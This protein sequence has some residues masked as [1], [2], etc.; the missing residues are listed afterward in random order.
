MYRKQFRKR[1]FYSFGISIVGLFIC[2]F[3]VDKIFNGFIYGLLYSFS[4][5]MPALLNIFYSQIFTLTGLLI[6]ILLLLW[7]IVNFLKSLCAVSSHIQQEHTDANNSDDFKQ[8]FDDIKHIQL[9]IQQKNIVQEEIMAKKQELIVHLSQEL[10]KPILYL[11]MYMEVL[12]DY[13]ISI[14]M[15]ERYQLQALEDAKRLKVVMDEFFQIARLQLY[16]QRRNF[17]TVNFG[18]MLDQLLEELPVLYTKKSLMIKKEINHSLEVHID[19][20]MMI[21]ALDEL[22]FNLCLYAI[23]K[24]CLQIHVR[25]DRGRVWLL[26]QAQGKHIS[27]MELETIKKSFATKVMN[28][29]HSIN[30]GFAYIQKIIEYHYGEMEIFSDDKN[31]YVNL[32]FEM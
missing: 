28:A 8:L 15:A 30:P 24:S 4:N 6:G 14:D 13:A 32:R 23:P 22:L 10:Q 21:L 29:E 5:N 19:K 26:A 3:I 17:Q 20:D 7:L 16:E 25:T 2:L 11:K 31:L 1:L 9:E 27:E 12:D 18:V